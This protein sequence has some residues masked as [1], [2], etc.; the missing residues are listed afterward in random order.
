MSELLSVIVPVYNNKKFLRQCV[1]SICNQT[2]THLEIIL[3]DDG[4]SD[5][6]ADLCN[7]L[8]VKDNRIRVIHKKNGGAISARKTGCENATGEYVTFVDS[9]DW[10]ERDMYEYLFKELLSN[11]V[12]IITSGFILSNGKALDSFLPNVYEGEELLQC[13]FPNMIYNIHENRGGIIGSVCNKIFRLELIKDAINLMEVS[14]QQ[15]EDLAYVYLAC[16]HAKRIQITNK[17]YYHYRENTLSVT[18]KYDPDYFFKSCYSF[19]YIEQYFEKND[20]KNL[21]DQL[22]YIRFWNMVHALEVELEKMIISRR[23]RVSI[24]RTII[25]S[26]ECREVLKKVDINDEKIEK[27][28]RKEINLLLK[29]KYLRAKIV[30]YIYRSKKIYWYIRDK[31]KENI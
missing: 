30:R 17:A 6:S 13:I 4:S 29:G 24:W 19:N 5:G 10:I 3:V 1:E 26:E 20:A 22:I 2:Y 8:M 16:Y 9:D 12:D 18:R 11:G 15:W 21:I 7:E 14:I 27:S 23:H 25:Q 28:V 31:W